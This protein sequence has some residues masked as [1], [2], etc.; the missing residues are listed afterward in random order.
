M[1]PAANVAT[2]A[3]FGVPM[4]MPLLCVVTNNWS[5]GVKNDKLGVFSK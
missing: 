3:T 4:R 5:V 2:S 1:I